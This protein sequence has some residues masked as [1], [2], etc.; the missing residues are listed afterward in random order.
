MERKYYVQTIAIN[1]LKNLVNEPD[2]I[3]IHDQ[4][5]HGLS[6]EEFAD[7]YNALL[8]L[9]RQLYDDIASNPA[10]FNM[11]LIDIKEQDEKSSDYTNSHNSFLRIPNLLYIIGAKSNIMPDMSLAIDGGALAADAKWLK[12][13]GLPLLLDKL[14]GYGFEISD[15]GKAP[16]AGE[17]LEVSFTDNRYL[18]AAL[19]SM[20]EATFELSKGERNTLKT[21][22]FYMMHPGIL[23]NETV[24]EPKLTVD[25]IL[26][27]LDTAQRESAESLHNAVAGRTKP[28]IAMRSFM[29]NDWR[30]TYTGL[31]NKKVLMSL[32][33]DQDNLS[34]KLNLQ[35]ISQ[36]ISIVAE[37]PDKIQNVIRDGG[38]Q[39]GQCNPRCSGGFAFEM[40]S[41]EYNKCHCSAFVFG[42]LAMEDMGY[43]QQLLERELQCH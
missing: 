31:K 17:T 18:T 39:C 15:F 14:R 16:K 43:Y 29:R 38:W 9:M 4:F 36:Y 5:L 25:S 42:G 24:K 11:A 23:E 7:G 32:N 41:N 13:T 19:K 30:I 35:N 10:G 37:M 20:A 3:R 8:S 28:T 40:D 34:A 27:V 2:S 22:Y 6:N 26:H 33:V 12:I 1:Y 21:N